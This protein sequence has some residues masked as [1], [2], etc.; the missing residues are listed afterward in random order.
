[1]NESELAKKLLSLIE[2]KDRAAAQRL[3]SDDFT[4]SGPVPEPISGPMWL[5]MHEKLGVAFP[6]WAFNPSDMR[7]EGD[8]VHVTMHITGTHQGELDLS[9]LGLPKVPA[10]GRR[11]KLP[12]EKGELR[13]ER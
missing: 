9:E 8:I 2:A 13:G 10:T 7:V 1:M 4:F 12:G 5:G 6:D 3:L 11:I